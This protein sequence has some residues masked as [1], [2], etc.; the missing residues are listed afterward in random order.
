MRLYFSDFVLFMQENHFSPLP[1]HDNHSDAVKLTGTGDDIIDNHKKKDVFR[2]SVLD[3]D[4]GRRDRWRDEERDTTS[5]VR[6]DRWREGEREQSDNRRLDRKVES[7]VRHYGEARRVPGE[8]WND[9]GNRDNNDQRRESKWNTRW[10]PGEKEAD[11]V[12][13]KWGDSNKEDDVLLDKGSSHA[14]Y[15]GKDEKDGDHYRP[16]RPNS[17]YSRGRADP[18]QQ[19][20]PLNKQV[21]MFPH[22]RG[23]GENPASSFT[24]GRGRVSSGG[25]SVPHMAIS[26]QPHGPVVEKGESGNVELHP[27]SYNRTKLID[28]YR[29]TDMILYS[30]Y[31]EGVVQVPSLTC[32]EPIEPLAFYPPTPEELVIPVSAVLEIW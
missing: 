18:Q 17:S 22:G 26:L 32:Q 7:S 2:P 14:P 23:R 1:G 4:S 9:S 27:F 25:S 28:I 5:S 31:L 13:E 20:S 11:A 24:L 29:T 30:K 3:M 19:N 12:R 6:K 21:P 8:R 10:G 15:H 16:W